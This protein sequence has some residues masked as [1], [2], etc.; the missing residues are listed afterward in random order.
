[1]SLEPFP[2]RAIAAEL[3]RRLPGVLARRVVRNARPLAPSAAPELERTPFGVFER[4]GLP[5]ISLLDG[6]RDSVKRSW[7]RY[8]WPVDA[9]FQLNAAGALPPALVDLA[10]RIASAPTL[11]VDAAEIADAIDPFVDRHTDLLCRTEIV[12]AVLGRNVVM[13]VRS[14]DDLAATAADYRAAASGHLRA[15]EAQGLDP[16]TAQALEI[17]CATGYLTFALAAEGVAR[18]VGLDKK[19]HGYVGALERPRMQTLLVPSE[20]SDPRLVEGDATAMPFDDESFDVVLSVTTLEHVSQIPE[21]FREIHRILRPGGLTLHVVDPWFSPRGGHSLCLLDSPWGHVRLAPDD[22]D[23]YVDTYRPFEAAE[24]K[25]FYREE[26]QVPRLTQ[27]AMQ[28]IVIDEGFELVDWQ[29]S[30]VRYRD[31]LPLLDRELLSDCLRLHAAMSVEDL[32]TDIYTL[33][34][35]KL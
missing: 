31:H 34:L 8:W 33:T 17:G 25:R 18:A 35:R 3:A 14:D 16:S 9:L 27:A 22:F 2:T 26:F 6:Y 28:R 11:P 20:G 10:D 12:D 4:D 15:L 21:V 32:W 19:L 7:R 29:G 23:R 5:P 1:V 13:T 30:G 24:A